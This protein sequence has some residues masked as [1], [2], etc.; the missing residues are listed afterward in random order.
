M[1][2]LGALSAVFEGGTLTQPHPCM[3]PYGSYQYIVTFDNTK[4]GSN[5]FTWGKLLIYRASRY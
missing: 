1:S 3:I 2:Y 4:Y 5:D